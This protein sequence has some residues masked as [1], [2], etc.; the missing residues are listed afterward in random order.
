[1]RSYFSLNIPRAV[2]KRQIKDQC[3]TS[4][5]MRGVWPHRI[6]GQD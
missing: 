3:A 5:C 4:G 1:M 2:H 6:G